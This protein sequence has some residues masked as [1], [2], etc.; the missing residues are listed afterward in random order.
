M[1]QSFQGSGGVCGKCDP[2]RGSVSPR[3]SEAEAD[4]AHH[5]LIAVRAAMRMDG[6]SAVPDTRGTRASSANETPLEQEIEGSSHTTAAR[7]EAQAE[8]TFAPLSVCAR[9]EGGY[10]LHSW[11]PPEAKYPWIDAGGP[12]GDTEAQVISDDMD[13]TSHPRYHHDDHCAQFFGTGST[14]PF[15][16][17]QPWVAPSSPLVGGTSKIVEQSTYSE[18]YRNKPLPT[19]QT[20]VSSASNAEI[21]A[22]ENLLG[23]VTA[24]Q[25][26]ADSHRGVASRYRVESNQGETRNILSP[27]DGST[28]VNTRVNTTTPFTSRAGEPGVMSMKADVFHGPPISKTSAA[29]THENLHLPC[30]HTNFIQLERNNQSTCTLMDTGDSENVGM[31]PEATTENVTEQLVVRKESTV[32]A[33]KHA[34]VGHG[35]VKGKLTGLGEGETSLPLETVRYER[36]HVG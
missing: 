25:E 5:L 28:T 29:E 23:F 21:H 3:G 35:I 33:D 17:R 16:A 36:P 8:L 18:F 34:R 30:D 24:A 22:A 7:G 1:A 14:A 9:C 32:L 26:N 2:R 6:N 15:E 20:D 13:R 12:E 19:K 27:V 31:P 4:I 10:H 11:Q